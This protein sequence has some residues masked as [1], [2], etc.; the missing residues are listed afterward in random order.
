MKWTEASI[1][2]DSFEYTASVTLT[3]VTLSLRLENII[4]SSFKSNIY[5]YIYIYIYMRIYAHTRTYT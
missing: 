3:V 4:Q 2:F 1:R 5:I